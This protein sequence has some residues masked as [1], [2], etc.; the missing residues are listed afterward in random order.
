MN[1]TLSKSVLQGQIKSPPSK[2]MAHRLLICASLANGTS[3]IHNIDYTVDFKA[4]AKA[5]ECLGATID[6]LDDAVTVHGINN[7]DAIE[8]DLSVDCYESGSTLRFIIPIFALSHKKIIFTGAKRLFERPLTPFEKIF[9]KQKLSFTLQGNTLTIKGPLQPGDFSLPGN[10]SSQFISGLCFALPTLPKKS[11][12]TITTPLESK[13]YILL[14]QNAQHMFGVHSTWVNN[15]HLSI[16]PDQTYKPTTVSVEGDWSQVAVFAVLGA[17]FGNICVTGLNPQSKQGD[18][19]ILDILTRCGA[20]YAWRDDA[21]FFE[22]SAKLKAPGDID[23]SDCPD[24]GPVLSALALFCKGTT[25]L[26]NA[27]R[28]RIKESDRI[29]CIEQEFEKIGAHITSTED[30]VTIQGNP[31]FKEN[32]QC[33]SHNDH[34]IAMALSVVALGAGISLTIQDAGAVSK[35]W[36]SFFNDL[37]KLGAQVKAHE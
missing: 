36:P 11:D 20:R 29:G 4:T 14:T 28:L 35:S 3:H 34:R 26:I 5:M 31:N 7:L 23:L 2:S 30:T 1:V 19:I 22:K 18:R 8:D 32:Q 33:N 24:L 13:S 25:R 16:S 6:Y 17:L 21:V 10:V 37:A 9:K 27:G 12:I 15:S